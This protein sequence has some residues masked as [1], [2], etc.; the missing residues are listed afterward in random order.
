MKIQEILNIRV[1]E[2]YQEQHQVEYYPADNRLSNTVTADISLPSGPLNIEDWDLNLCR[3]KRVHSWLE[4]FKFDFDL[5]TSYVR[6]G[7]NL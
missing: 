3:L 6:R 7:R 1:L 4:I 2:R 5:M